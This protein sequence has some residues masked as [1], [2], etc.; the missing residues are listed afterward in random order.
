MKKINKFFDL[1]MSF[2]NT[3]SLIVGAF[4]AGYVFPKDLNF[5]AP[6]NDWIYPVI[7]SV[8]TFFV[9]Y[10]IVAIPLAIPAILAFFV[11][12]IHSLLKKNKK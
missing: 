12:L 5:L 7:L 6:I 8:V 10:F 4:L 2:L 1:Y 3:I 11:D 9:G